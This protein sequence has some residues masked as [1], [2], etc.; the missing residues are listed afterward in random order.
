MLARVKAIATSPLPPLIPCSDSHFNKVLRTMLAVLPRRQTDDVSGELFVS[1]YKH[2]LGHLPVE[3]INYIAD[4]ALGQCKWFPTIAECL[5]LLEGW[6]R[7]DVHTERKAA[8]NKLMRHEDTVRFRETS[9]FW[10]RDDKPWKPDP[11]EI[12]RI[13]AEVATSLKANKAA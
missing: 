12:A 3:A 7:Y 8:A 13:K 11:E 5:E 10:R 4:K 6:R 9:K 1:A 2:K